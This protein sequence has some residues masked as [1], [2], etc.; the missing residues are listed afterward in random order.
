M[1]EILV[2]QETKKPKQQNKKLQHK[3][4]PDL[5]VKEILFE[6]KNLFTIDGCWKY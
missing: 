1:R 3:L 4:H 6:K 2:I 5:T